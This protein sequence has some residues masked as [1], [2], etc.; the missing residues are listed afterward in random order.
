M[1]LREWLLRIAGTFRS[2]RAVDLQDEMRLHLEVETEA[3]IRR[4]L[5]REH[6]LR[7]ARLRIGQLPQAM[8][9]V[10]DQQGHPWLTGSLAD[11][12]HSIVALRR[13][14]SF[15]AIAL[16]A[17]AFSVAVSTLVF[18]MVEGVLLKPLPYRDPA[19]LIRVFDSSARLPRFPV[20]TGV[21]EEYKRS[22][23]TLESI[24]L[25]TQSD[26]QLTHDE[27]A[28]PMSAVRVTADFFPLSVCRR[29]W[30]ATLVNR[31]PKAKR[32]SSSS[33]IFCGQRVFTL[34]AASSERRSG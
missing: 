7:E 2:T 29:R 18:T 13:H 10:R 20:S 6:A 8:E 16:A 32:V 27:R 28:E 19:Q 1:K 9:S 22:S 5:T 3:G 31:K 17:L 14:P 33:V 30:V 15:S 4:G 12:R 11:L 34:I 25:Y 26:L 23:R 21:Y 24:A